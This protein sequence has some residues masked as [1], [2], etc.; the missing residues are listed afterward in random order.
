LKH[1][2]ERGLK[3]VRLIVSNE[4]VEASIEETFGYYAFPEEYWPGRVLAPDQ[5]EQPAGAPP[6]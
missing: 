1:L 3:G 4:L 2:K 6:E 5:D